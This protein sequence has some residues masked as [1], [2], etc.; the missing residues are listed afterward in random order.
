M[1]ALGV[2]L[3]ILSDRNLL[4]QIA[5]LKISCLNFFFQSLE[6]FLL[7]GKPLAIDVHANLGA[8]KPG[9]VPCLPLRDL[10]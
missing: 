9:A 5:R 10:L 1:S 2:L 7:V 3:L 4:V 8:A 6:N